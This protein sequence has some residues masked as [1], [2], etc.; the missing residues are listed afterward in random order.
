MQKL[1]NAFYWSS[2][3]RRIRSSIGLSKAFTEK[4]RHKPRVFLRIA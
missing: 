1:G 4:S 3:H 2:F